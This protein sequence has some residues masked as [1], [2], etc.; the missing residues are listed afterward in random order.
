M[1]SFYHVGISFQKNIHDKEIFWMS[2]VSK[3][4]I[5]FLKNY[6][7]FATQTPFKNKTQELFLQN[8]FP[9]KN[10]FF[11]FINISLSLQ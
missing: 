9:T 1:S 8:K 2:K 4:N 7:I 11:F 6:G 10:F 3:R 5:S